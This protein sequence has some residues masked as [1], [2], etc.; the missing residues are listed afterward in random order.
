MSR[1][2]RGQALTFVLSKTKQFSHLLNNATMSKEI[3]TDITIQA[4]PEKVWAILTNFEQYP[5]WN[6]FI[7]S[8]TGEA[9]VGQRISAVIQPPQSKAMT[10]KPKVLAFEPHREFRWLGNLLFPGIFDGEHRFVLVDNANGT[11]TLQ[12][13]ERF[14]GLLIGLLNMENTRNGFEAMNRK[15]KELAEQP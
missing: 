13:S 6:P 5:H 10:F 9:K 3:K 2:G 8:I 12:H 14:S 7:K 4:S 15:L 11:T 1:A